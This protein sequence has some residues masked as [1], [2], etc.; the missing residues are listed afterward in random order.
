[1]KRTIFFVL[2]LCISHL[3]RSQN[4]IINPGFETWS[5]SGNPAGWTTSINCYKDSV[6]VN[7]GK[8]SCRHE[9]ATSGTKSVGQKLTVSHGKLYRFSFFYITKIIAAEHGCRIWCHWEDAEGK[10]ITDPLTDDILQPSDYMKSESWQ[11][12]S[13]EI[14]APMNAEKFSLE[15][16]TYQNSIAHLDNFIFEEIYATVTEYKN[17]S[18]AEIYPNPVQDNLIINNIRNLQQVDIFDFKGTSVWSS[19]FSGEQMVTIPVSGLSPG[20]Y[21]LKIHS[22]GEIIT[23][24]FVRKTY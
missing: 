22:D 4:L 10:T 1:M 20:V 9:G 23:G 14:A 21:I 3:S 12:F 8:Y 17:G 18:R 6:S 5:K 16:R 15:V 19:H 11:K 24:R 13:V 7:S 2:L